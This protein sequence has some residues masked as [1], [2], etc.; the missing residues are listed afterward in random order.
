[1]YLKKEYKKMRY[2]HNEDE[3]ILERLFEKYYYELGGQ[4]IT[5]ERR[6]ELAE[7][8]AEERMYWK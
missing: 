6:E 7:Q 3:D 5:E 8:M 2:L 4:D 1:M